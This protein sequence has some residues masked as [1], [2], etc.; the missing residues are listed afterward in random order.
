MATRPKKPAQTGRK[1][2]TRATGEALEAK[3]QEAIRMRNNN[4][5]RAQI[6]KELQ[7]TPRTVT[8]YLKDAPPPPPPA[9]DAVIHGK[10]QPPLPQDEPITPRPTMDPADRAEVKDYSGPPKVVEYLKSAERRQAQP[11]QPG[12]GAAVQ[13]DSVAEMIADR[14]RKEIADLLAEAPIAVWDRSARYALAL[15][16]VF[17]AMAATDAPWKVRLDAAKW[18]LMHGDERHRYGAHQEHLHVFPVQAPA[19]APIELNDAGDGIRQEADALGAIM[20]LIG[21]TSA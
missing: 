6:A 14:R 12:E 2:R 8:R 11:R 10:P 15:G 21:R 4:M 13:A 19:N 17:Q 5:T 16:T 18:Y 1:K 7:V 20:G 3:R 9:G